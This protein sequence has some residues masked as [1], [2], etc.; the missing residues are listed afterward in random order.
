MRPPFVTKVTKRFGDW[1]WQK[2][3]SSRA[4][5]TCLVGG[6]RRL[7]AFALK[8]WFSTCGRSLQVVRE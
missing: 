4:A 8:Q 5:W 6:G 7:A 2:L 1:S 3:A